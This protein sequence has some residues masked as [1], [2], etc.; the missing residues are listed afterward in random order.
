MS[1][2]WTQGAQLAARSTLGASAFPFRPS[3]PVVHRFLGSGGSDFRVSGKDVNGPG[4]NWT[5]LPGHFKAH[6]YSTLG[7]GKTF[8]PKSP[9]NFDYPTS[10]T[11]WRPRQAG[12]VSANYFDYSYWLTPKHT[13]NKYPGP[14]PGFPL[15]NAS[16]NNA[17]KAL[18]GN[19]AVWCALDEPDGNFYDHGL[20]DDTIARLRY[21][22]QDLNQTGRPFFIASGFARPHTPW[23]VPQRFW[24]MYITEDIRLATHKLPPP[25]MPGV[26]WQAHSFFNASTSEVWLFN[27]S[28][29]L[30]DPI[31]QL[32]RHGYY[33]SVSWMDYQV[34]RILD[35]LAALGL[36]N[37]TA[38]ALH[39]DHGW[40]LG[41]R[42]GVAGGGARTFQGE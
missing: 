35:E 10:W 39:G 9:P 21:A 6:N 31:A 4:A 27:I 42:R 8:H 32:A 34:G 3:R 14:C 25:N 40:Q 38:V 28:T 1:E 30:P 7:G 13:H 22:A 24:D 2:R 15:P 29:P 19:I 36:E 17:T 41:E 26:S 16:L 11:D 12:N 37:T 20:A 5:T 23:R 33:A 18:S